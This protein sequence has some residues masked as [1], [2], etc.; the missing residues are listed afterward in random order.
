MEVTPE[1]LVRLS[2]NECAE[3]PE[4]HCYSFLSLWGRLLSDEGEIWDRADLEIGE[5]MIFLNL[6]CVQRRCPDEEVRHYAREQLRKPFWD[7]QRAKSIM[8]H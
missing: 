5:D 7:R 8:E 3:W 1:V 4:C 2:R 6:C